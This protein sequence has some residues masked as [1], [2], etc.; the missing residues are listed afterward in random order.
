M[1]DTYK[2]IKKLSNVELERMKKE[3]EINKGDCQSAGSH[4]SCRRILASINREIQIR[5]K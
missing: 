4:R 1:L 3:L 2:E 5:K